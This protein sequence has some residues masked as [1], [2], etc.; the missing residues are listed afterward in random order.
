M[1]DYSKPELRDSASIE[2]I[3]VGMRDFKQVIALLYLTSECTNPRSSYLDFAIFV[4]LNIHE[5][6]LIE[7]ILTDK[8]AFFEP[9]EQNMEDDEWS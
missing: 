3:H 1:D 2:L 6:Y 9:V 5:L 7:R 8:Q 4:C